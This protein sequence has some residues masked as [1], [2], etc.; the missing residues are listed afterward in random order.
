M[1][2]KFS[3]AQ[4]FFY[5]VYKI[6][7]SKHCRVKELQFLGTMISTEVLARQEVCVKG[8]F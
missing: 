6:H 7:I 1:S 8:E 5:L 2:I 3:I 4:F